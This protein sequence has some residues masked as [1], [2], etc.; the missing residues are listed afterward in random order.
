[1]KFEGSYTGPDGTTSPTGPIVDVFIRVDQVLIGIEVTLDHMSADE[2]QQ[3]L[4][5]LVERAEAAIVGAPI[6]PR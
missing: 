5:H 3:V 2:M 4:E 6:P 1:M